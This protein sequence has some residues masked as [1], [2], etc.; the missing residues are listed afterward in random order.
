MQN[1]A[2]VWNGLAARQRVIVAA[3][4][5]AVF[6]AV[7]LISRLAMQPN[8]ALLYAGLEGSAAADVITALE[9]RGVPY[10]VRGDAI[11]AP[12]SERD[13]LRI[14]LAGEGLPQNGT[15]GYELLD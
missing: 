13:A 14:A 15:A 11:Y 5:L 6:A 10:Q 9:Q 2:T 7:L 4:A 8:L 1:L 3:S 12:Q